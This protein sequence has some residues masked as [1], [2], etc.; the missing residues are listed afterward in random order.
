M[1]EPIRKDLPVFLH[2][3]DVAIE[4]KGAAEGIGGLAVAGRQTALR[5][6]VPPQRSRWRGHV[7]R[8][9]GAFCN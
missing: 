7:G 9:I 3:G 4:I 6:R 8:C 2:D 1:A 5:N